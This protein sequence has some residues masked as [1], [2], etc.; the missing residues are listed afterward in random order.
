MTGKGMG[1]CG[2][3][4]AALLAAALA[5]GVAPAVTTTSAASAAPSKGQARIVSLSF[6]DE[7]VSQG[8]VGDLLAARHLQGTFFIISRSVNTGNDPESMTGAP[9]HRLAVQGNEIGG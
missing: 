7:R 3:R 6:D 2:G 4:V 1:R 9:I 5:L 8:V